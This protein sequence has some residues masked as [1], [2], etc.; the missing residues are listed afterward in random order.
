[1]QAGYAN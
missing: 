1:M